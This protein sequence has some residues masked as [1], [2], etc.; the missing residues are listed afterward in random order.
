MV[1]AALTAC[2]DA[3]VLEPDLPEG[4]DLPRTC[5]VTG[6][7]LVVDEPVLLLATGH[8]RD[9]VTGRAVLLPGEPFSY[10]VSVWNRGDQRSTAT[11]LSIRHGTTDDEV[12]VP[13]LDPGQVF[14]DTLDA[15]APTSLRL[16]HDTVMV[17]AELFTLQSSEDPLH[18]NNARASMP[19]FVALPV[20]RATLEFPDTVR[21]GE[22]FNATVTVRNLSRF[23]DLPPHAMA[24]CL[25]D[26]DVGCGVGLVGSPFQL[27]AV[28]QIDAGSSWT[29]TLAVTVSD[30]SPYSPLS[31]DLIACFADANAA[32]EDFLDWEVR[33]CVG[34]V[35]RLTVLEPAAGQRGEPPPSSSLGYWSSPAAR[36]I[37]SL[38]RSRRKVS[39]RSAPRCSAWSWPAVLRSRR[40]RSMRMVS[41]CSPDR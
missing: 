39:C 19:F 20:V 11:T 22:P 38:P 37:R 36:R 32:L 16:R 24:F 29:A 30:H 25:F 8:E 33:M 9:P 2:G 6:I 40:S 31:W 23:A 1:A 10:Q 18:A 26:Y 4:C 17:T 27:T 15:V 12:S 5:Q 28:P 14:V 41:R 3:A 35:E 21:E 34:D 13:G 7:D